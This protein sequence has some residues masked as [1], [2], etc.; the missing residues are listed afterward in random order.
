MFVTFIRHGQIPANVDHRYIGRTD[1]QLSPLGEQQA[2]QVEAPAVDK[3]FTSPLTRCIQ[4][5][6][7]MF[8]GVPKTVVDDFREMDFGIFEGRTPDEMVDFEPYRQWVD[9]MCEDPIPEGEQLDSFQERCRAA[10]EQVVQ[11][12]DQDDRLAIVAHG[13]TIMAIMGALNDEGMRY[14]DYHLDN[15]ETITCQV[16]LSPTLRLHRVS[17]Y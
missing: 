9:S 11:Q 10:F 8:P 3:V 12:C 4:T 5:A 14:F 16:L 15:C 1:Q 17:A 7:I 2:A 13:G 6:D